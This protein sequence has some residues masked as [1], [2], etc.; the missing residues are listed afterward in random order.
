MPGFLSIKERISDFESKLRM[1][2]FSFPGNQ[3]LIRMR[4]FTLIVS[5]LILLNPPVA[6]QQQVTSRYR[7]EAD[8]GYGFPESICLKI[9]YG[10]QIQLGLN[11]A[12]DTQGLGPSSLEI[13]YR[14]GEKPRGIY[15]GPWY[16]L[17]GIAGYLFDVDYKK[18]YG[19]FFYPRGG[20]SF[21]LS[22][23]SGINVD[24][25]PG[26]PFG[27]DIESGNPISPVLFTGSMTFFLKF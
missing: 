23:I 11:Q 16:I 17:G 3:G 25:G 4:L 8:I 14:L 18:K 13:Y 5:G 15:Q 27:R 26:F 24:I 7:F 21:Y 12:F 10:N 9:K 20:R 22:K 1:P 19:L 2:G 6:S